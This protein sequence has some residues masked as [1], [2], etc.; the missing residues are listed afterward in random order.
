[1]IRDESNLQ[2]AI[3]DLDNHRLDEVL[4][5]IADDNGVDVHD[6]IHDLTSR[7][8]SRPSPVHKAIV[9]LASASTIRIVTTNYDHH[10]ST[11]LDQLHGELPADVAA[12]FH[13]VTLAGGEINAHVSVLGVADVVEVRP[14]VGHLGVVGDNEG[15]R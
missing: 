1:M 9:E 7:K 11:L 14:R 15:S 2:S 13:A 10:L 3:G 6:R 12:D 4:G 8:G 5:R